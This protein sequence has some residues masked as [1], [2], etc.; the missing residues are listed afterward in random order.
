MEI[1][2]KFVTKPS[3]WILGVDGTI[4]KLPA[5]AKHKVDN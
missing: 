4:R 3:F 2:G 5:S 1:K